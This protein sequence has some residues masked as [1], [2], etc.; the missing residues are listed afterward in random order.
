[1]DN[2]IEQIWNKVW[3]PILVKED[4]KIDI[5]QVKK[6]LFDY[7]VII[8]EMSKVYN[9][10][11]NGQVSKPNTAADVV[12]AMNDDIVTKSYDDGYNDSLEDN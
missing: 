1:M 4:G 8:G 2:D 10:V 6:E 12:I 7:Y 9:S 5:E 3:K 11:T